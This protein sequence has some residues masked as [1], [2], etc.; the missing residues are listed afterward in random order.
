MSKIRES[1]FELYKKTTLESW[2]IGLLSGLLI[3]GFIGLGFVSFIL[4]LI[5]VPFFCIPIIFAAHISHYSLRFGREITFTG[6]LRQFFA[7]FRRPFSSSFSF[8][9]SFL[10]SLIVFFIGQTVFAV[11][12]YYI[13]S[14]INPGLTDSMNHFIEVYSNNVEMTMDAFDELLLE[15]NGALLLFVAISEIPAFVLSFLV[16]TYFAS[17]SSLGIFIRI[18]TPSNNVQFIRAVQADATRNHRGEMAKDYWSLNWPLFVLLLLG[19][20]GGGIGFSFINNDPEICLA[21]A[22]TGGALLGSFFLPFYL[23]NMEAIY[24]K[25]REAFATSAKNISKLIMSSIE[26]NIQENIDEMEKLKKQ[27]EEEGLYKENPDQEEEKEK[28]PD[29]TES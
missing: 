16:F 28:D 7:Y 3:S 19:A 27:L 21:A 10:K 25:Y 12:G 22:L 17:R 14:T 11:I 5:A 2:I 26:V 13:A 29:D 24:D 18:N 1:A 23:N 9:P 15:N 6:T 20:A 4:T 8:F